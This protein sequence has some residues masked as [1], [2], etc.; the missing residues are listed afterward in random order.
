VSSFIHSPLVWIPSLLKSINIVPASDWCTEFFVIAKLSIVIWVFCESSILAPAYTLK[1]SQHLFPFPKFWS[2]GL[3]F[4]F[5]P[6]SVN[7]GATAKCGQL[8]WKK[9]SSSHSKPLAAAV[10]TRQSVKWRKGL[11]LLELHNESTFREA[12]IKQ[13][14]VVI[15]F[16]VN[17]AP[18]FSSLF[19]VCCWPLEFVLFLCSWGP[20][21]CSI[22]VIVKTGVD[23]CSSARTYSNLSSSTFRQ[24]W[25]VCA[26]LDFFL[27]GF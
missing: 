14:I 10:A 17:P 23:H 13:L 15:I 21:L 1:R 22:V 4:S 8:Q 16:Y 24:W 7:L 25:I 11:R 3:P 26:L 5:L 20:F 9:R 6:W 12:P 27:P 19:M 18:R 2:I